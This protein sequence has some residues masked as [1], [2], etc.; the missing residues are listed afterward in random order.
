[1][2]YYFTACDKNA[3]KHYD[4][5]VAVPYRIADLFDKLEPEVQSTLTTY[6]LN[7]YVHMWGA[8]PG[9]QN[10]KRWSR[11]KSNDG[12]L[13]YTKEGFTYYAKVLC[14]THNREVAKH[15]WGEDTKRR[16]WEYIYFLK[17][18]QEVS[19]PKEVFSAYFGYK[20]N[21]TP[22]GFS[23]I[24]KEKLGIRM[25]RYT[26]LDELVDDLSNKFILSEDDLEENN[27]QTSLESDFSKIPIDSPEIKQRRKNPKK[28]NGMEAWPRSAKISKIALKKANFKCEIDQSHITFVSDASKEFYVEAHHLIPMKFQNEFTTSIDTESNVV[29]LCPLCHRKIHLAR[30]NEKKELLQI[31]YNKRNDLLRNNVEIDISLQDLYGFYAIN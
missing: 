28:I 11:L 3:R 8:V 17:D 22:Q 16:T 13:V 20:I 7:E 31:L 6:G 12:M 21:F 14:K 25:R 30:K 26:V 18:L 5:T 4:E 15:V 1:M 24:D 23:N 10:I 29:A 19:I 2:L 27:F 9:D